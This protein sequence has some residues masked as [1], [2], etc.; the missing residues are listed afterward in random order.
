MNNFKFYNFLSAEVDLRNGFKKISKG[1]KLDK[2]DKEA[3]SEIIKMI[4]EFITDKNLYDD[5][6]IEKQ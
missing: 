2:E 1:E 4:N 6:F 3:L 5:F